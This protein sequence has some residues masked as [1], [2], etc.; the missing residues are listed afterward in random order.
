MLTNFNF[1]DDEDDEEFQLDPLDWLLDDEAD[2]A[3]EEV[4]AR[5]V[6]APHATT[7]AAAAAAAA[8]MAGA[9]HG[10][11]A[12]AAAAAAGDAACP[13]RSVREAARRAAE[14]IAAKQHQ[15][16]LWQQQQQLQQQQ[17]Q[18]QQQLQQQQLQVDGAPHMMLPQGQQHGE[19][20]QLLLPPLIPAAASGNNSLHDLN[21]AATAAAA[22]EGWPVQPAERQQHLALQG[23]QHAHVPHLLDAGLH[24]PTAW[25]MPP[26]DA[27]AAAAAAESPL[28]AA[29]TVALQAR[30]VQQLYHQVSLHT[31]LL[32]QL[33]AMTAQDQSPEAQTIACA[34]GQM[35]QQIRH[36]DATASSRLHG[37]AFGEMVQHE[38]QAG[39]SSSS[40]RLAGAGPQLVT[41]W[42]PPIWD[43]K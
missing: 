30:Q 32:L 3:E 28:A 4:L 29:L 19:Q 14:R 25:H 12:A 42:Q 22:L 7:A 16:M 27:A 43:M 6:H 20:Q 13:R 26:D 15:A 34:V 11:G 36:L 5:L 40:S 41:P 33:Y 2:A 37:A 31:Q 23:Q 9:A 17:Q 39:R 10:E 38:F 1:I 8:C 18:L 21:L 35:L 24:S